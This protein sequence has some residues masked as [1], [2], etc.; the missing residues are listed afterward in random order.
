MTKKALTE[1]SELN[2]PDQTELLREY[3]YYLESLPLTCDPKTK[4]ERFAAWLLKK[5]IV[6][7]THL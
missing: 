7:N 3:G 6:F 1:W 5:G 2:E 4:N